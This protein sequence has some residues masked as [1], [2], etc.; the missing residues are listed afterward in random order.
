MV[1]EER[2]REVDEEVEMMRK[3]GYGLNGFS[4]SFRNIWASKTREERMKD[5]QMLM[6]DIELESGNGGNF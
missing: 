2:K 1:S 3:V 5:L 4:A 6:S